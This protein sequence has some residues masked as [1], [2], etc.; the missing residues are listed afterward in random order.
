MEVLAHR[1][2]LDL[3]CL[4]QQVR[5]LFAVL[6][7]DRRLHSFRHGDARYPLLH[8]NGGVDEGRLL[9]PAGPGAQREVVVTFPLDDEAIAV[10]SERLGPGFSVRDMRA[11]GP[12]ADLVLAPPCSPQAIGHLKRAYLGAQLVI[13]ELDDLLRGVELRGPVSRSLAAGADAY[14]VAPST[15]ALGAFLS[16][17]SRDPSVATR[18]VA[19]TSTRRG[20]EA[21]QSDEV[22]TKKIRES[23]TTNPT[24][25]VR[26]GREKRPDRAPDP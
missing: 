22:R 1:E 15:E 18:E 16:A 6:D 10:L 11:D 12:P 13:V 4:A 26:R 3:G 25:A 20:L 2:M 17:L 5:K 8:Y 19:A 24:E 21:S 23:K 14:Y 7:H 9:D